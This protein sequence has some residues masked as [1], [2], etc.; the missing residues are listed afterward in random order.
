MGTASASTDARSLAVELSARIRGEVRFDDASR[1]LYATDASNYRHVPIGVVLPRD[2]EDVVATVEVCREASAPILARGAGTSIAGQCCNVAVVLDLSRHL[3]QVEAIDAER[4]LARVQPGAILDH[5]RT[6]AEQFHLTFGPDPATHAWCTLGGMVANN[7]C[8]AHSLLAGMTADNIESL[9]VL[10]YDGLRM[11]VG[12]TSEPEVDRI[13]GQGGR[14]GEIYARLRALRDRYADLIRA[15]YPKIPRTCSGYNLP[16]LLPENGFNVARALSGSEGTC[17]VILDIGA[18]LVHSPPARVLVVLGYADIFAAGDA[19]KDILAFAPIALEGFDDRV[20]ASMRKKRLYLNDLPLLPDGRG[21]LLV[22]FGAESVPEAEDLARRLMHALER[23]QPGP[24]ARLFVDQREQ[25]RVWGVR[26]AGLGASA[27][28]P[29]EPPTW[30]GWEDAAVPP[31]RVGN[32]LRDLSALLERYGYQTGFY[33]H[34]GQGCLHNRI[35]FDLETVTGIDKFRGFLEQAADLVVSY[36]GSISGEHGDGQARAELLPRMFGPELVQAFREFK[37]I[38]DRH[39]KMNPGK[40][41]DPYPLDHNLRLGAG[42]S[43]PTVVTQFSFPDDSGSFGR[44]TLRCVGVGKCHRA[45]GGA[46]C[47]SYMVTHDE[48]H[49][50]RGRT[51]L[52]NEML[53]GDLVHGGWRNEDVK[54]ALDLCLACKACKSECPVNVDVAMYKSEFLAHYYAGRLRPPLAYGVGLIMY[55]SRLA[56]RA[57]WLANFFTRTPVVSD[58]VKRLAGVA[59]QRRLPTYAAQPFRRWFRTRPLR[60]VGG[61]SVL[62]WPD[63]FNNFMHP[64][65]AQAA[66]DVL[67]TLGYQ[68]LVPQQPLCCGRPVYDYGFIG[69]GKHLL[70]QVL[71]ALQPQIEAGIPLVGLEPSCVAVFRDELLNLMPENPLARRLSQQSFVLSEFLERNNTPLPRM[72]C[73]AIVQGHCH[74]RAVMHLDDEERVLT[75]LGLRYSFPETA[76]CGM[77]GGFGFHQGDQ[78]DVSIEC[79]ER[80]LLPAVRAAAPETLIIANGFSCGEQIAQT[81]GRRP[82]HLAQVIQMAFHSPQGGPEHGD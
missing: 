57:P 60:N 51:H 75:R 30:E 38:W 43:L 14:R 50:P 74:H 64:D 32:Y 58:V 5:L 46:M 20:V 7:S 73:E 11:R 18:R 23:M 24:S 59:P 52:L 47:P 36:G 54:H 62:L 44:A 78:F 28:P 1:A 31:E 22:E 72:E 2:V 37:T 34:I 70:R 49:N 10:T 55:W 13:I 26:E 19:V 76:C 80:A 66:V 82:L 68:V 12:P 61:P 25:A 6:R 39:G 15:R 48:Q 21:W 42:F 53:R 17:A 3:N 4:K 81:T 79:G 65:V 35:N 69:V 77:A 56:G 9:D 8:G 40:L 71:A 33:G 29:G 63:T 16:A 45:E 67:E 27:F 41:V